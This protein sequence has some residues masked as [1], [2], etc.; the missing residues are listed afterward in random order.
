MSLV[1]YNSL[2]R[3]KEKF[4]P[5][6]AGEV[7][8]YCCGPTVYGLLHVGNFR[9][10][11]FY[12]LVRNWLE[13]LGYKVTH[14]YNYT[15]VDDKIIKRAI[16]E[17]KTAS[18]ISEFYI[19]EFEK[20][21][22]SLKLRSHSQNPKVTE[23]MEPIKEMISTLIEKENAY[24]ADGEILY[25]IKSFPDYGKLSNRNPDDL[26]AG[27][28]VSVDQK[29]KDPLDFALW[30][31]AKA[32]EPF[33]PSPWGNGR[34]GWH[35]ECSAMAK[36]ILGA[37]ID[38]HGGGIDLLFPHH[39]NEV[40]QSEA[41]NGQPFAK[42][43][44]HHNL[45]NFAG[46]KM[47]KSLGNIKTARAF[48]EERNPE[49]YK[50]MML[51][52]HY[53]SISDF[54]EQSVQHAIQ[55]LARIYS[56]LNLAEGFLSAEATPDKMFDQSLKEAWE[57]VEL[58]LND[59]FNTPEAFARVFEVVRNFNSNVKPGMKANPT[60]SGKADAFKKFVIKF[61]QFMSL[62]QEP[63]GEYLRSLDDM[64]LAEKKLNRNEIDALVQERWT[65]R[66]AKDF[67]RSDEVRDQLL[68]MGISVSDT[69]TGSQWEVT[70]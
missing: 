60:V 45:L 67:K 55:G 19:Q 1:V 28:R 8:M 53:R 49:I 15:D 29:K 33:W 50:Y 6:K 17:G 14:I 2:S 64:L 23:Y 61:G 48:F 22:A 62:F 18:E 42:F 25:S 9:G 21:F 66:L 70:K 43:W 20:D 35:I 47:S 59:D 52:A 54:S 24:N 56:A 26:R 30:K 51:S 41:C 12:N 10:A 40:A 63:A 34:P 3:Q 7:K 32:G 38:I 4:V 46:E 31:P 69:A 58:A 65:A 39:E 11:V 5:L 13:H 16:D 44:L 68:K 27:E 36:S 57:K 37:Q